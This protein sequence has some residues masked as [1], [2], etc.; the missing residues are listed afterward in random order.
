MR[1]LLVALVVILTV[2]SAAVARGNGE[3]V[4]GR[5]ESRRGVAIE[6]AHVVDLASGTAVYT[7][8]RGRFALSCVRPCQLI[9]GHSRFVD[10]E[11]TVDDGEADLLVVQ[12]TAKQEVFEEI[13]VTASRGTGDVFAPE[14]IASTAV[15]ADEKTVA[16]T[17]LT[18]L[19]EGVAGVAENGQGGLFQVF[20]IRGVSRHRVLT[21]VV[22]RAGSPASA[23]PGCRRRSSTRCSS[24]RSTCCGGRR[25]PTTARGP[26]AGWPRSFPSR[27]DGLCDSPPATSGFGDGELPARRAG[28]M[29]ANAA[30]GRGQLV[31]RP[32]PR[33]RATTRGPTAGELLNSHFDPGLGHSGAEDA[34]SGTVSELRAALAILQPR[35]ATTSASPTPTSPS[36]PRSTPRSAT[37]CSSSA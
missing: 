9:V 16:P 14:T 15:H 12:L 24:A 31:C 11:L 27:F 23:G 21:L 1:S 5:V 8:S 35:P 19:V 22:G 26:W 18:E 3:P 2:S 20:A 30:K 10:V 32:R 36:A 25:R 37:C 13:V 7:D 29:T 33:G 17:T 4:K 34:G 6:Q 28:A